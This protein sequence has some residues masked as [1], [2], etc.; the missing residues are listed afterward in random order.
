MEAMVGYWTSFARTGKP[1]AANAPAWPAYGSTAAYMDFQDVP[2][3]SKNLLP[4][5]FDL[6][7][8]VVCR[9]HASG[10]QAWTWN[11][12]IVAPKLPPKTAA[13]N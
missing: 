4:G 3:A 9:R 11:V 7:D 6:V 2:K 5:M 10:D 1:A 8:Q 12:G 13:C